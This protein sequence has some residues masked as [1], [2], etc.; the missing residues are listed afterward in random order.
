MQFIKDLQKTKSQTKQFDQ[1]QKTL[2]GSKSLTQSQYANISAKILIGQHGGPAG[3]SKKLSKNDLTSK[4]L[5]GVKGQGNNFPN[6]VLNGMTTGV[7]HGNIY[8]N[9]GPA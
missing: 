5:A 4:F 2:A 8:S 3:H 7:S 9:A 1:L 6:S